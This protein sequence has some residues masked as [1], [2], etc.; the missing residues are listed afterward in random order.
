ML[1]GKLWV[2]SAFDLTAAQIVSSST[3]CTALPSADN[4]FCYGFMH[5]D[6]TTQQQEE[7]WVDTLGRTVKQ[8]LQPLFVALAP[9]QLPDKPKDGQSELA[10]LLTVTTSKK[11]TVRTT[12]RVRSAVDNFPDSSVALFYTKE[13]PGALLKSLPTRCTLASIDSAERSALQKFCEP[14]IIMQ[15]THPTIRHLADSLVGGVGERCQRMAILTDYVYRTIRKRNTAT[16]SSALETL[17]A[18]YGDCGEHAVLLGALARAANIPARMVLGLVYV[19]SAK[20]FQYH[21]WVALWEGEWFFAD[22]AF[23]IFPAHTGLLPL[24]LDDSGQ[25][26]AVVARMMGRFSIDVIDKK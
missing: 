6:L 20:G 9:G 25:Q 12:L 24:V 17:A 15:S 23:G 19:P 4:G 26:G 10:E 8:Q 14:S 21:A 11:P 3:L 1:L 2:D 18:G 13:R 5:T 7:W 16:F 22:A